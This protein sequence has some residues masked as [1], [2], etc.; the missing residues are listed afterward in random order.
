MTDFGA[1]HG[2]ESIEGAALWGLGTL[3]PDP[4]GASHR[5]RFLALIA[6]KGLVDP[7]RFFWSL[8]PIGDPPP[9]AAPPRPSGQT[10]RRVPPYCSPQS[11]WG[12]VSTHG[13]AANDP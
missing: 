7:D 2:M 13:A 5:A 10:R 8:L 1:E 11:E 6:D 12:S 4:A 3:H 9:G